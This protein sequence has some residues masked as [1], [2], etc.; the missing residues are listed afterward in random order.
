MSLVTVYRRDTGVKVRVPEHWLEH[1]R[2]GAPFSKTKPVKGG[3]PVTVSDSKK[4]GK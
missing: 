4:E 1:P 2:L 3:K